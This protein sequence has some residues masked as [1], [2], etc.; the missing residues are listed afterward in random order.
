MPYT[1][2]P[3]VRSSTSEAAWL[4][5]VEANLEK[6]F[7]DGVLRV[8]RSTPLAGKTVVV[9]INT[10]TNPEQVVFTAPG[11]E[12]ALAQIGDSLSTSS[13]PFSSENSGYFVVVDK[14]PAGNWVQVQRGIGNVSGSKAESVAVTSNTQIQVF[15][16]CP[17]LSNYAAS[18]QYKTDIKGPFMDL[19]ASLLP[20]LAGSTGGV[21]PTGPPGPAG[22]Q[23]PSGTN[24]TNGTNGVT[25]PTGLTGGPGA[26]GPTGLTVT[27][28]TGLTGSTVTGPT[29]ATGLTGSTVTGPTGGT[30]STGGTGPTGLTGST[31]TGPTGPGGYFIVTGNCRYADCSGHTGYFSDG[32]NGGT[33][34]IP[35]FMSPVKGYIASE[36]TVVTAG[37]PGG[38][39]TAAF[40]VRK[41][42]NYGGSWT[43]TNLTCT[44][45][46]TDQIASDTHSL[47]MDVGYMIGVRVVTTAETGGPWIA[48]VKITPP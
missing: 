1:P 4:T 18:A 13:P 16:S 43:T 14:D 12:F 39:D 32:P 37:P 15:L 21:G 30:G 3:L 17:P 44:M 47:N 48:A 25:G 11:T 8:I 26:T 19:A 7:T 42:T 23:G 28:P 31:V 24:G 29:G 10:N 20:L 9:S 6:A 5:D 36:L 46:G 34:D 38:T 33:V 40:W 27:G 45:T 35:M 22:P 2:D 41:S